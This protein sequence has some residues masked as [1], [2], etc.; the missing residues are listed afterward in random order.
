MSG[1][2]KDLRPENVDHYVNHIDTVIA[3]RD[4]LNMSVAYANRRITNVD[5]TKEWNKFKLT[6]W[7]ENETPI[8]R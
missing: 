6:I 4:T 3:P 1:Q 8:A 7:L 2:T 5:G